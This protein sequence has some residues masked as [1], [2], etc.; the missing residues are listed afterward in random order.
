MVWYPRRELIEY[1]HDA[2]IHRYGG[3]LGFHR[4]PS[5]LDMIVAQTRRCEGGIYRK[6]AF[7]LRSLITAH[8]F[9]DGQHRT[10]FFVTVMFLEQ[11]G[12]S[13]HCDDYGQARTFLKGIRMYDNDQIARWLEFG[14]P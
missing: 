14:H 11:N 5:L 9:R 6:A 7:L 10:A 12:E 1:I 3:R 13:V 2:Q 4:D 8:V